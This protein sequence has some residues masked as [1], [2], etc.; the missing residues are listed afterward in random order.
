MPEHLRRCL[1]AAWAAALAL[2]LLALGA[3]PLRA[4]ERPWLE[5]KS[6]HF[7]AVSDVGEKP[8]R[9]ALWAFE[10]L[11]AAVHK[12]LPWAGVDP[13][14][15]IV[16]L[17]PKGEDG[18]RELLPYLAERKQ[19]IP[20]SVMSASGAD[21]YYIAFRT[22]TA[23]DQ[24][25][26]YNQYRQP[27]WTYLSLV[28]QIGSSRDLPPWLR[29]GL[30]TVVSNT[31]LHESS[32]DVGY[33]IVSNLQTL[34]KGELIPYAEVV[35]ADSYLW[36]KE[37]LKMHAFNAEA[38][39][40]A[41]YLL[42]AGDGAY[43][44]QLSRCLQLVFEGKTPAAAFQLAVGDADKVAL[45]VKSYVRQL[46][47]PFKRVDADA[48]I[49]P[50]AFTTRDM[51]TSDTALVRGGFYAAQRRPVEARAEVEAARAHIAPAA[52]FELEGILFDAD[53][54]TQEA[55]AA[56]K[57][58]LELGTT[59]FYAYYRKAALTPASDVTGR[60]ERERLLERATALAPRYAPALILLADTKVALGKANDA[61]GIARGAVALDSAR[62]PSRMA[63]ARVLW[64]LS[65]RD[66]AVSAAREALELAR[67][68]P[69]RQ[70]VQRLIDQYTRPRSQFD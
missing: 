48:T 22:D 40:L 12:L 63:L 49:S 45:G 25:R 43:R 50:A 17:L 69:E 41:H 56:Y 28:L 60:T 30:A 59:N 35:A 51:L 36:A 14:R 1:P 70:M 39:G 42:F 61:L 13:D 11:R 58:A 46:T 10:Q 15:P 38:W 68:D 33:P 52:I 2:V 23:S 5:V 8:A 34:R 3:A 4:A 32:L 19:T 65:Q 6:P 16:L 31:Y 21:R 26:D 57:R 9:E 7:V 24:R 29:T 67:T 53:R 18:M 37:P 54:K 44:E 20:P 55:L 66:A 27:F 47:V 64:A 62:V